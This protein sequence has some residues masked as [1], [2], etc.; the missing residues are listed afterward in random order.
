MGATGSGGEER[1]SLEPAPTS[2]SVPVFFAT[3]EP[4]ETERLA[5]A[6]GPPTATVVLD[7]TL[8]NFFSGAPRLGG[9]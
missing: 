9:T 4:P 5:V 3:D 7:E 6:T 8:E 2:R 1:S